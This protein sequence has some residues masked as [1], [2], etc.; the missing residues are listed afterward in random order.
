M[1]P[2]QEIHC[3]IQ[4]RS[5]S[6]LYACYR[7]WKMLLINYSFLFPQQRGWVISPLLKSVASFRSP[8]GLRSDARSTKILCVAPWLLLY[9]WSSH[10]N[11][12]GTAPWRM[13]HMAQAELPRVVPTEIILDQTTKSNPK[14]MSQ[15]NER[16]LTKAAELPLICSQLQT[17]KQIQQTPANPRP[18]QLNP[19]TKL[20]SYE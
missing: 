2:L 8:S 7:L 18:E 20:V 17:H 11:T 1:P 5:K 13:W 6:L 4:L 14:P 12:L 9:L 15:V 10:G 3:Q 16:H 19:A